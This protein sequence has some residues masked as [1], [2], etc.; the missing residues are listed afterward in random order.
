[1]DLRTQL[2]F[3]ADP[4]TVFAMFTDEAYLARKASAT[5]AVRHEASVTRLGDHVT[6]RLLRV[7]PPDVPDLL[8]GFVGETIDLD[9][10]DVW[11]PASPDGSR[12]GS[13]RIEMGGAPVHLTGG[14][15]L[16]G[17]AAATAATIDAK[18]KASI[19]LVGG[20]IEKA[21]HDAVVHA[22]RIEEQ[23]GRAWLAADRSR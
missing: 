4:I 18:V 1:M 20:R 16:V 5:G 13:I 17:T 3:D 23:V 9:Q 2:R 19:P 14:M 11:E 22:A 6:V 7:M 8:R 12:T 15:T 10:T 21:V